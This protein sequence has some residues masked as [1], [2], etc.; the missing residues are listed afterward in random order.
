MSRHTGSDHSALSW[1]KKEL[2]ET[3]KQAGQALEAYT[4][5]PEDDGQLRFCATHLHQVHGILQMLELFGAALLAEEMEALT[6]SLL[7][8]QVR[9]RDEAYEVLMR[10]ILQLPDYLERLQGG[11]Q[12]VPVLLLPLM[13]DMRAA[14]GAALLTDNAFFAPDL[15]AGAAQA[16]HAQR[17]GGLQEQAKALRHRFQL[18]L[19]AYLRGQGAAK[20]LRQ[21]LQ[22][23]DQLD[24]ASADDQTGTLWWVAAGLVEA[25]EAGALETSVSVK[26]L[27]GQVDRQIKRAGVEG[28]EAMQ[29]SPPRDLIRN[30][31]YYVARAEALG[32]R[33]PAI[34]AQY[35]LK[36]LLLDEEQIRQAQQGM[37]TPN[38]EILGTV[39]GAVGEDMAAVKDAL[40]L[41]ARSGQPD[42]ER[43]A[44]LVE[45][46]K[47]IADTLGILGLGAP[48]KAVK[49]QVDFINDLRSG[50]ARLDE[51]QLMR[52][53][54]ALLYV[55]S[56]LASL[57]GGRSTAEAEQTEIGEAGDS[58]FESEFQ[59]VF[60]NALGEAAVEF[61]QAKEAIVRY[62]EDED[63][64]GLPKVPEHFANVRGML[65]LLNLRRAAGLVGAAR[66]CVTECLLE[67]ETVPGGE[68]L[69][70]LADGITSLEYYLEG[71]REQRGGTEQILD[72]AQKA[73]ERLGYPPLADEDSEP[74]LVASNA[75]PASEA[76]AAD[77]PVTHE[78]AADGDAF[79]FGE[80]T[81]DEEPEQAEPEPEP[82]AVEPQPQEAAAPTTEPTVDEDPAP[83]APP[84]VAVKP[85]GRVNLEIEEFGEDLDDEILDIFLE[86]AD[87]VLETLRE[88]V[89]KWQA[90]PD[91]QGALGTTRRMF[92]T[93]KGSGRLAGALLLG[94]LA[95]ACEN[96]L[97]QVL[98]RGVD[99]A[100]P[101]VHRVI[102]ESM[103]F[104]PG[105]VAQMRDG[106]RPE[107]DIRGLMHRTDLLADP[108][109]H[110]ELAELEA[111][112]S[113]EAPAGPAAEDSAAGAPHAEAGDAAPEASD[114]QPE[115]L[116]AEEGVEE[117]SSAGDQEF[118]WDNAQVEEIEL[119]AP[120]PYEDDQV[121]LES[122]EAPD[123][124]TQ[125][126]A[127]A[128]QP[129]EEPA[130]DPVLYEIF[131]SET[132]DH[133]ST[134]REQLARTD[135]EGGA[136]ANDALLRALHTLTG[137]AHMADVDPIARVGRALERF[138]NGR[139]ERQ[140]TLGADDLALM[141]EGAELIDQLVEALG[142]PGG[143]LPEV[144]SFL[145]R[146]AERSDEAA[147]AGYLAAAAF[148]L[149]AEPSEDE[150]T[151]S[152][153]QAT[154]AEAPR[155]APEPLAD[156]PVER[157]A[158]EEAHAAGGGFDDV[159]EELIDL[160]LEEAEDILQFMESTVERWEEAPEH[161]GTI[162]ELHRSLHTLKGGARLAGFNGIGS[163]CH[164]LE[165]LSGEVAEHK[166]PAD[167]SF[168]NLLHE[169]L[170]GLNALVVQ[171]R[172][173]QR[174]EAPVELM[175]RIAL[176]R[177]LEVDAVGAM[178]DDFADLADEELVEVFLEE[179][180]DIL[181]SSEAQLHEWSDNPQHVELVVELQRALHTLKGGARMAGF[182]PIADLG[183]ALEN[184]LVGVQKQ[185]VAVGPGLF[186][187]LER[188]FDCLYSQREQAEQKQ[189][190]APAAKLIEEIARYRD[191]GGEDEPA[192]PVPP[193]AAPEAGKPESEAAPAP[194]VEG[195]PELPARAASK[196]ES[197][198]SQDV[199]RVHSGLLDNLVNYAG[200]VSIYRARLEQQV[201]AFRFNLGEL[202]Q[203]VSRLREQL[204]TMEIETETQI[205]YRFERENEGVEAEE[206]E[207]D[208]DPLEL[209]RF[210]GIQETSRGLSESVNDLLSIQNMLD[211]LSREAE[212]LL[213]QQSR[214]NT[215]LQDGLMRTRMVPFANMVPRM[216]RI[217]RQT[218]QELG[219]Q[220]QIHVQGA[221][222]EM[223]RTVLER[224][225]PP[226]EHMLR[227][228]IAHGI[229][230]PQA[231][232]AAGKP[233]TGTI[234]VAFYR[235]GADVVVRVSDDGAGMNLQAIRDKAVSRGLM[236][237]NAPL[238]DK[239]IMQFVLEAGFSTAQEVNQ[240]AGRGV[241]MDVVNAEIK[242]LGGTLDID[243]VDGLGTTFTVRL[244]FTLAMNQALLCQAGEETYAI[245]LS[246]IEG[247]VRMSHEELEECLRHPEQANYQYGEERYEVRSLAVLLGAGEPVLPGPGKRA[248]LILVQTGD[249]RLALQVDGLLGN[250]EIVVKSVGA[251]ISTVPGIF[252]AT[253]LADGRVVLILDIS[254]LV[255]LGITQ[256]I[257]EEAG[258]GAGEREQVRAK[259]LI[260]VV[261]DSITMRKVATRLL[262]R[263]GMDVVTAKDGVDAVA[264]LQEHLPDAM[265]LDIEMPRMDGYELATHMRND[266]RLKGVPIIMITSRTGE[267]HRQRAMDIGVNR[268]L[269]KPYQESDLLENLQELLG[270]GGGSD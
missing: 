104:L 34:Q 45:T 133:L 71:L 211:H 235:E 105:L 83:D 266:A 63:S 194:S 56:A 30:L 49:E 158:S 18:G 102:N 247:V 153:A 38:A 179:A 227:N 221:Q 32:E 203:T 94:E 209:D 269:G 36:D 54:E 255:R 166:V 177:G 163:L 64:T 174:P 216:R 152:R 70:A 258:G 90:N 88:E 172:A 242:Q 254:S 3:L 59:Q 48:R 112:S 138:A 234:N 9:N 79:T 131:S 40:D 11:Q 91:D 207:E 251:Q 171:A 264:Q 117:V 241:G 122:P 47:R 225:V 62:I 192:I 162:A 119:S 212:T 67:S 195:L 169:S 233:E 8:E 240:I 178:E 120:A 270:A 191:G 109:R 116:A 55:E 97:N 23:L 82:E 230:A 99:A 58:L 176:M 93:L 210:S 155:V 14:R 118:D 31:M 150:F 204:R 127:P 1:V 196:E 43:L 15:E 108:S 151:V 267:K 262:E 53:A 139:R 115:L 148:D 245:P 239:E 113:A 142:Q 149:D 249:H 76:P 66:N 140:E 92:H 168:F 72:V 265:L 124:G 24:G 160:F 16:R 137:S 161:A 181:A 130:M 260:M 125:R 27:L 201:G 5:E 229:E 68:A 96:L 26:M 73:L 147:G 185:Q 193:V 114:E 237:E 184:L 84:A 42:E 157:V 222:G 215:E 197:R 231:R 28:E 51:A 256:L 132:R 52:T 170:D 188:V 180:S 98:E 175:A 145:G 226:L 156:I 134:A 10:G 199:V 74:E 208:F 213:L 187:L 21:M 77:G 146:L 141:H 78:E 46:L 100:D 107:G 217:V 206:P 2:D 44:G 121:A 143:A 69:D 189:P 261:D 200:E 220:A 205:L 252:G 80:L 246:S 103:A 228:A 244:P 22:V 253:I 25:L 224:M 6:Q 81:L 41:M 259:R 219:R 236:P 238:T 167:D 183:H 257:S 13:N 20:G 4:E 123:T 126:D 101:R 144:E 50:D 7:E 106:S 159:D 95:W 37:S 198:A 165:S 202:D 218:G 35:G 111:A 110:D 173:G 129:V 17:G 33:V 186:D 60:D 248:P 154:E 65:R 263:N 75:A 268:Y 85:T 86:E 190:L 135:A 39:A 29:V 19:L 243:S 250:R 61:G 87:E 164:V 223:D 136:P 57:A 214:V 232:A 182:A 128:A 89:P 12:D